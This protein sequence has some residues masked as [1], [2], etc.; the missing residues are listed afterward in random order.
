MPLQMPPIN[1]H[2][3]ALQGG[4]HVGFK[5]YWVSNEE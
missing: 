5:H 3:F 1:G 2:V 4:I